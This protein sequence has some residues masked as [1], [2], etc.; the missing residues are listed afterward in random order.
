MSDQRNG[1]W[2][3][4]LP[5]LSSFC[6]RRNV[7]KIQLKEVQIRESA[8]IVSRENAIREASVIHAGQRERVCFTAYYTYVYFTWIARSTTRLKLVPEVVLK[9]D[10]VSYTGTWV[11]VRLECRH[12]LP[13]VLCNCERNIRR[14]G[15]GG[16]DHCH[17]IW[18]STH[19]ADYSPSTHADLPSIGHIGSTLWIMT[20]SMYDSCSLASDAWTDSIMCLR[21]RPL[22]SVLLI[23]SIFH[24]S[25]IKY[26]KCNY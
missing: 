5:D 25:I 23:H 7:K 15:G 24:S 14:G 3:C 6:T 10:S 13:Y 21:E 4:V 12:G 20:M 8:Y 22:P 16:G 2:F 9:L 18:T 11:S 17:W 19:W 1:F 26:N